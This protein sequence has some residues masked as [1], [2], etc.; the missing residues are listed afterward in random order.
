[1]H[2]LQ[3]RHCG[4]KYHWREAFSKFGFADGDGDIKTPHI[5]E[6]L[7]FA[8]YEVSCFWWRP[9][10][11]IIYSIRKGGIEYMPLNKSRNGIGYTDPIDYLPI[12]ILELPEEQSPTKILFL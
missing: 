7:E 12:E 5:A 8:G 9:H 1:M 10:N 2:H 11:M 6:A 4:N 3:C